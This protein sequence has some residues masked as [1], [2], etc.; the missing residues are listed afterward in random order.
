MKNKKCWVLV[1]LLGTCASVICAANKTDSQISPKFISVDDRDTLMGLRGVLVLVEDLNPE[2]EKYGLTKQQLQI[3]VELR[4]RQNGIRVLSQKERLSTSEAPYL[5]VN[6]NTMTDRTDSP[7]LVSF[8]ILLEL[9][10]NV[11]LV[12]DTSPLKLCTASTW[13]SFLMGRVDLGKITFIRDSVKDIVDKFI[14]DYLAANPKE[15]PVSP[16]EVNKPKDS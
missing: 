10:Q 2:V 3:D 13:Q 4:L 14:N 6:V 12:K 16:E 5:Y 7:R 9:K 11:F 1:T 8:S 15:Q